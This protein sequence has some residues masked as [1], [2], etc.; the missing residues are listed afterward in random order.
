MEGNFRP[1][2][3]VVINCVLNVP[4]MLISIVG[5]T[6]VLSAILRTPSLRSPSAMFFCCLAVSDLTVGFVVQPLYI[7]YKLT[8]NL[9]VYRALP[10]MAASGTGV[11]LLVMTGISVDRI[12]A[13]HY[14]M[15]YPSLMTMQRVM[16]ISATILLII[17]LLSFLIFGKRVH[18]IL[19]R[20]LPLSFVSSFPLVVTYKS[21]G[22]FVSIS[23]L[24]TFNS[25]L[26]KAKIIEPIRICS[27]WKKVL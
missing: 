10:I 7:T 12:L 16:Y 14:H 19:L 8:G 1:N 13:L 5:N 25:R 21:F 11:S 22:L 15:R 23:Y 24:F 6:L 9:Y 4:L 18:I 27:A 17:V 26:W 2:S 20:L 3:I